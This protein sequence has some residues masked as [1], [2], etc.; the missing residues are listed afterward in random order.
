MQNNQRTQPLV[1]ILRNVAGAAAIASIAMLAT[2]CKSDSASKP[3]QGKNTPGSAEITREHVA[4]VEVTAVDAKTRELTLKNSEG[5][6]FTVVATAAV[7]NF[8][9]IHVGDSVSM[10]YTDTVAVTLVKPGSAITPTGATISANTGAE[11]NKSDSTVSRQIT[12]TVR[13]DS[14]DTAKHVVGFTGPHGDKQVVDVVTPE[15]KEFIKGIKPGDQVQITYTAA[16]AM[17]VE[18]K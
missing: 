3:A 14:V 15:G 16:V 8:D 7:T 10:R 18:K 17:S 9:Q 2:G 1:Q 11:G 12:A 6:T 5:K 13:I 4:S